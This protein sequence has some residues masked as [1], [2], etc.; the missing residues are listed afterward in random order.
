MM[1]NIE[2]E[3][4]NIIIQMQTT[5]LMVQVILEDYA[6]RIAKYEGIDSNEIIININK[7]TQEKLAEFKNIII[8][9]NNELG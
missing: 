8:N 1:N 2:K 3:F 6:T 5:Y 4:E 7:L 9:Q